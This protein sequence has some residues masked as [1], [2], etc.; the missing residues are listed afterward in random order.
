MTT[1]RAGEPRNE[2][3]T[4]EREP[5]ERTVAP[6]VEREHETQAG[7]VEEDEQRKRQPD[8]SPDESNR[9]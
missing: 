8:T 9:K 4:D 6:P 5:R 1:E 7:V 3:R 2:P